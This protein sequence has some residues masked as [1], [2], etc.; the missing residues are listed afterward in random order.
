MGDKVIRGNF[1]GMIS[2]D[3]FINIPMNLHS[4][5]FVEATMAKKNKVLICSNL[6][7]RLDLNGLVFVKNT[8][9]LIK[10]GSVW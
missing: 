4:L 1:R 10:R 2:S 3:L 6:L 5:S 9:N 8:K 7:S